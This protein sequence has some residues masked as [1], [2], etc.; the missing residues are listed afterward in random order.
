MCSNRP[1]LEVALEPKHDLSATTPGNLLGLLRIWR[2]IRP[3]MP[4]LPFP[5]ARFLLLRYGKDPVHL[6][7]GLQPLHRLH[8]SALFLDSLMAWSLQIRTIT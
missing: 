8:P 7:A 4:L 6:Q 2:G 1:S 5:L 3:V